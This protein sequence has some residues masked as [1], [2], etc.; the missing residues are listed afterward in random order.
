MYYKPFKF[1]I[2]KSQ[3]LTLRVS[4]HLPCPK[5]YQ[6]VPPI[7][8]MPE[9]WKLSYFFLSFIS[10]PSKKSLRPII[11]YPESLLYS[12]L[13]SILTATVLVQ[14]TLLTA[15]CPCTGLQGSQTFCGFQHSLFTHTAGCLH[16]DSSHLECPSRKKKKKSIK[17]K[18]AHQ[19]ICTYS[20]W[21]VSP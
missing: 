17:K 15:L 14:P 19:V 2:S 1:W 16:W 10:V 13:I 3:L 7:P 11:L 6:Q 18:N 21:H 5:F 8:P 12:P 20:K 9:P 4:K